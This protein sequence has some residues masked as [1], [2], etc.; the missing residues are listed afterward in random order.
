MI[1]VIM[2]IYNGELYLREAIE[3][4]LNQTYSDFELI[5]ID[6]GSTD[7]TLNIL[8][9]YS[10]IDD[11]VIIVSR[12]NKGLIHTLNEGLSRAKYDFIARMDA[13]DISHEDRFIVQVNYLKAHL[14]VAV[15]GCAYEYIDE[16]AKV[17]GVRKAYESD[18]LLKSIC[19]LGSPFAHPGVMINRTLLSNELYYNSDFKHAEDYEL[20]VR[21]ARKFK[22]GS[23]NKVLLKYR[24]LNSS[25]SRNNFVEQ[26]MNMAKAANY[27]IFNGKLS[28]FEID[29]L[30]SFYINGNVSYQ[31][32]RIFFKQ[33]NIASLL[34][35]LG[36]LFLK[37]TMLKTS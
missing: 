33:D 34:I 36:Y 20:W 11:R 8:N 7:N 3:S 6:D 26:K 19:L 37:K 32:M 17:I 5:C 30:R 9:E 10:A 1:S 29:A 16:N 2:P 15:V 24:V 22:L 35:Q 4:I 28:D 23:I 13:D 27:H 18:F 12:E 21:L 25:V 31:T 14:D